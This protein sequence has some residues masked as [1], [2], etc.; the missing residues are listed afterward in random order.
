MTVTE[1]I[2]A[3]QAFDGNGTIAIEV[4]ETG[5]VLETL[6]LH[7]DYAEIDGEITIVADV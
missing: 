5:E 6:K 3:L 7:A 1:L 2:R 4:K